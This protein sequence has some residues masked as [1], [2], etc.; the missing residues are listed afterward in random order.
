MSM[1]KNTRIK[2]GINTQFRFEAFNATNTPVFSGDPNNTPTS[3]N[4]GKIIRDNG[5]NNAPRSI[6]FGFRVQF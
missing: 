6:Q 4:F 3:T 1:I 5:Q 2:E